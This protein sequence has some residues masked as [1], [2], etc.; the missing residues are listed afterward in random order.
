MTTQ[1]VEKPV[2][3]VV[4]GELIMDK[5]R[6]S[7]LLGIAPKPAVAEHEEML[8]KFTNMKVWK[9]PVGEAAIGG[10]GAVVASKAIA[11]MFP[12]ISDPVASDVA[13]FVLLEKFGNRIL[14]KAG[15]D[16]AQLVLTVDILRFTFPSVENTLLGFINKLPQFGVGMKP[17]VVPSVGTRPA[18]VAAMREAPTANQHQG[19][20]SLVVN[21]LAVTN[22]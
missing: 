9:F 22:I 18:G 2:G 5:E 6:M 11:R 3:A 14:G 20:G 7:A 12:V 8:G 17:F 13:A 1:V 21:R 15:T 19:G 16:A 10:L 4:N